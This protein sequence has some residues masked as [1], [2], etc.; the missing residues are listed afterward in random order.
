MFQRK[1]KIKRKEEIMR[2]IKNASNVPS[3]HDINVECWENNVDL[4][5]TCICDI[6]VI[7]LY[8]YEREYESI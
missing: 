3:N 5:A 2:K 6:I 8:V 7:L 1:E 4:N